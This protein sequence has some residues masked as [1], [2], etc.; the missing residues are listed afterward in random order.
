M[1]KI[2]KKALKVISAA[3]VDLTKS[4]K[5]QRKIVEIFH[6]PYLQFLSK[7]VDSEIAVDGKNIK[8]R[9][10]FPEKESDKVLLFFHGGGWGTGTLDSY[11]KTCVTLAKQTDHVVV[12][13]DYRLAPEFPYPAAVEDCYAVAKDLFINHTLLKVPSENITLIGDSAGGN[14]AAVVSLM[15]RDKEE[16]YPQRQILIYPATYNDHSKDSPFISV[17]EKGEDYVLTAKKLREYMELYIQNK[18]DFNSPYFA[19]LLA[20]DLSN[21]PDTLIITAE[22]DPLRDEGEAYGY[23]LRDYHNKV[24]IHE[25]KDTIHGFF[26]LSLIPGPLEESYKYINTF[27]KGGESNAKK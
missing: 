2:V 14:L 13:V 8:V 15:A 22:H 23:R 27:L 10:F 11:N 21:Q 9:V 12:S 3:N 4:Y 5:L 7:T 16:F 20:D 6:F 17:R 26:S 19:P 18:E 25:I 24:E 1:K